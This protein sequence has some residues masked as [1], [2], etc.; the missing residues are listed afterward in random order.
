MEIHC[1]RRSIGHFSHF[2]WIRY[3]CSFHIYGPIY[4]ATRVFF[5]AGF[6]HVRATGKNKTSGFH[7]YFKIDP[8][9]VEPPMLDFVNLAPQGASLDVIAPFDA[10]LEV[11]FPS[12]AKSVSITDTEGRHDVVIKHAPY[13]D[14]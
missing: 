13:K 5:T 1:N 6:I 12:V 7:T 10:A 11:K 9:F 2:V 3:F 8:T 14:A 4:S